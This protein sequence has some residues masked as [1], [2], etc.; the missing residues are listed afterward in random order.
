MPWAYCSIFTSRAFRACI[1]KQILGCWYLIVLVKAFSD[2]R[3]GRL[4]RAEEVCLPSF[5]GAIRA[6][7]RAY[8]SWL[9]STQLAP[10]LKCTAPLAQASNPQPSGLRPNF[11]SVSPQPC[12][13][14]Y[15]LDWV[16]ITAYDLIHSSS[17]SGRDLWSGSLSHQ[18]LEE[19]IRA[20]L[21]R[22]VFASHFSSCSY[23]LC[24]AEGCRKQSSPTHFY[25]YTAALTKSRERFSL[26]AA[27]KPTVCCALRSVCLT[28]RFLFLIWTE[29]LLTSCFHSGSTHSSPLK[30][31]SS[32][33]KTFF[34]L[35]PRLLPALHIVTL[36]SL[37][38]ICAKEQDMACSKYRKRR[39]L[40]LSLVFF[41]LFTVSPLISDQTTVSVTDSVSVLY[42][43][44]GGGTKT[45]E[46]ARLAGITTAAGGESKRE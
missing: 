24:R 8:A 1:C 19:W 30:F 44:F 13:R 22:N 43:S 25:H 3:D 12:G 46:K 41:P 39:S 9:P 33:L 15:H 10:A 37:N 32:S 29:C 26:F 2:T 38:C 40:F 16:N 21:R 20:R 14:Q 31:Q 42:C 4:L 6:H 27:H 35:Y 17:S 45:G 23:S 34:F 18:L 28:S 11:T 7:V 36:Y 5:C